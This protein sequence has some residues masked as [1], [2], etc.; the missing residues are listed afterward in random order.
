MICFQKT[1]I[2]LRLISV[3]ILLESVNSS[4]IIPAQLQPNLW[5]LIDLEL[6]LDTIQVE[7]VS[8]AFCI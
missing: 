1:K 2:K 6:S 3:A 5:I 8:K 7:Q 4:S